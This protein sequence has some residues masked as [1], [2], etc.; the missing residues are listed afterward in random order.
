[1]RAIS[2]AS[3][4]EEFEGE[5]VDDEDDVTLEDVTGGNVSIIPVAVPFRSPIQQ[6]G[7]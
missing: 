4:C 6:T 7:R 2:G 5:V 1:M 3:R